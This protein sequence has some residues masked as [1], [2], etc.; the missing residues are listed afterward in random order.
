[1]E[2]EL[3]Y[4]QVLELI[5][6]KTAPSFWKYDCKIITEEMTLRVL[7]VISLDISSDFTNNY[8]DEK[9]ITLAMTQGD[10]DRYVYPHRE[11]LRISLDK[12][13]T[14]NNG[15]PTESKIFKCQYIA[16]PQSIKDNDLQDKPLID[17]DQ[18]IIKVK[19]DLHDLVSF[20][21]RYMTY[22]VPVSDTIGGDYVEIAYFEKMNSLNLP[23]EFKPKG[24]T[25][26]PFNVKTPRE[27]MVLP[28]GLNLMDLPIY[29]QKNEGGIYEYGIGMYYHSYY[30]NW[31]MYPLYDTN[32]YLSSK[33]NLDIYLA[34]S[35]K[36]LGLDNTWCMVNE[37]RT[38]ISVLSTSGFNQ[39]DTSDVDFLIDGN[40]IKFSIAKKVWNGFM[41]GEGNEGN[42]SGDHRAE[43]LLKKRNSKNQT[44]KTLDKRV[45]NNV[46][47]E[48]SM[49][50]QRAGNIIM[51]NWEYCELEYL[52]PGMPCRVFYSTESDEKYLQGVLLKVIGFERSTEDGPAPDKVMKGSSRLLIFVED[53][54]LEIKV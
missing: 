36:S 7:S 31:F 48:M 40:G 53:P 3:S 22:N 54:D 8:A 5:T 39:V 24:I 50:A 13:P 14:T 15:V 42:I 2:E 23:D 6:N 27:T 34:R 9:V 21:M 43:F 4:N 29:I 25:S 26:A 38:T 18:Q 45:T 37:G 52:I 10:Y 28:H 35:N 41:E 51:V 49:L 20:N 47:H 17:K 11:N 46:A 1:M 12:I 44:F 33:Y 16:I 30:R 19:F 32:R